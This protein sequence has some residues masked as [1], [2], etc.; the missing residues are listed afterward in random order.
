[1][2]ESAFSPRERSASSDVAHHSVDE[3]RSDVRTPLRVLLVEDDYLV[4][5][6][7]EH[8]L[9]AAGFEMIGTA[10]SADEAVA[11]AESRKPDLAVMDIRLVGRRDG[12]DAAFELKEKFGI[13]SVFATAHAD[14]PTRARAETANPLGWLQKPYSA[15]E[16]VALIKSFRL[17][18]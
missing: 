6:Q 12:V 7:M 15:D 8:Q 13:R 16:L 5:L 11:L 10:S 4:A 1:M 2:A 14:A 9:A 17:Q 3:P 18:G